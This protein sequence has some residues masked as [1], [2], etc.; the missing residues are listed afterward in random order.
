MAATIKFD[1]TGLPAGDNNRS[2]SDIVAGTAV[3]ITNVSPGT[4]NTLELLWKP[5]DDDT[6]VITGSSPAWQIVP[7]AGVYG[8]YRVKLTVDGVVNI[9]TFTV[10]SPRLGLAVFAANEKA[11][12]TASLIK[13]TSAEIDASE[14]NEPFDPF[15]GGSAFGWWPALKELIDA[16]EESGG[17]RTTQ[18]LDIYV[19]AVDGDDSNPGTQAAPLATIA[20]AIEMIPLIVDHTIRIH[21]GNNSG[22]PY[23]FPIIWNRDLNKNVYLL[24]DG[25]GVGDGF[26]ELLASTAALAGSD[27]NV[28]KT[29]G[30]A[31]D[32]YLGKTIEILTGAAAGDR[33]TIRNN[34]ATDIIPCATFSSPVA[35]ADTYR[36]VEP[37][38][39]IDLLKG[40]SDWNKPAIVGCGAPFDVTDGT[41][42]TR[43]MKYLSFVNLKLDGSPYGDFNA[44]KS[45]ILLLGCETSG[46]AFLILSDASV[47]A[48]Y[49][50]YDDL[51]QDAVITPIADLGGIA[52]TRSWQG[53]G[54][55]NPDGSLTLA[56][57]GL[58]G[59][60][61]TSAEFK[62]THEAQTFIIGG[63]VK[64]GISNVVG[65][66]D[67]ARCWFYS[68]TGG[69][70]RFLVGGNPCIRIRVG[71]FAFVY[72]ELYGPGNGIEALQ[73]ARIL[74]VGV[75]G[76]VTG[77]G[78]VTKYG[79]QLHNDHSITLTGT[80]G[81]FSEDGGS[82]IR[83]A[84]AL[85][86]DTAF[87][88][89]ANNSKIWRADY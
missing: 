49:E 39:S 35:P 64:N 43:D 56:G 82:T 38:I 45:N 79:G 16:V 4:V 8:T 50:G 24:G 51:W 74:N 11:D 69:D 9:K 20:K 22:G 55:G 12:P 54:L 73:Y 57:K 70:P 68:H 52:N 44:Q 28:V 81:D 71:F 27:G 10:R 72:I 84:A 7:K 48:G 31:V 14:R 40:L 77:I 21:I 32:V 33:R 6:A 83:A 80:A 60:L 58:A 66:M 65:N 17:I 76:N 18:E 46:G 23:A 59:Y 34:T 37:L 15:S 25:A 86:K 47:R 36:I 62:T 5:P 30:L 53:W 26:N 42:Y 2:R 61:V 29:S 85:A 63:H 1:Q 41:K 89:A 67:G 19:R 3:T 87:I 75:I 13:N 88:D 78:Q